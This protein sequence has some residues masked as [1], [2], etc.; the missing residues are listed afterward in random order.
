MVIHIA[1][2]NIRRITDTT[3]IIL[4]ILTRTRLP[5]QVVIDVRFAG[6]VAK[7]EEPSREDRD[8]ILLVRDACE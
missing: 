8:G 2:E 5:A 4:V 6:W 3:L 7:S 1:H